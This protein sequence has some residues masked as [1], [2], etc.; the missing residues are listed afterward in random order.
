[1]YGGTREELLRE[2]FF[3][4]LGL[5]LNPEGYVTSYVGLSLGFCSFSERVFS[6][7]CGLQVLGAILNIWPKWVHV[8]LNRVC[9][10]GS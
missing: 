1:M 7:Y 8:L 2:F 9:F 10:S 6:K 4:Q 5:F 3:Y